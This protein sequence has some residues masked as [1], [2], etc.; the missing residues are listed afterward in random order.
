MVFEVNSKYGE[1]MSSAKWNK[2]FD[3]IYGAN[4]VMR[5]YD[6]Q[7]D[8]E[9]SRLILSPGNCIVNG[10][11]ITCD[12]ETYY[13]ITSTQLAE[14]SSIISCILFLSARLA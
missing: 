7:H 1:L 6:I 3:T 14:N 12:T 2:R 8:E 11:E 9:N 4:V 10:A 5:G 13:P